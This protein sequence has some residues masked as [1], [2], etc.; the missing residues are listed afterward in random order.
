VAPLWPPSTAVAH[1]KRHRVGE[2]LPGLATADRV[3]VEVHQAVQ[4]GQR[5]TSVHPQDGETRRA[6]AS[7]VQAHRVGADRRQRW[8]S[9]PRRLTPNQAVDVPKQVVSVLDALED[10]PSPPC[11]VDRLL[12][13]SV[14]RSGQIG[15]VPVD[16]GP[17]PKIERRPPDVVDRWQRPHEDLLGG[18]AA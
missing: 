3:A 6:E 16:L 12:I 7:A 14:E 11:P 8:L 18:L 5:Q 13:V 10:L 4:L 15:E 9:R 2:S 17:L 1:L